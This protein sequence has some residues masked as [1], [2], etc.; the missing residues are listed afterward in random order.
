[1]K[2]N[3]IEEGTDAKILD[4]IYSARTQQFLLL[5]QYHTVQLQHCE[6]SDTFSACWA[7]LVFR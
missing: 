7:I 3:S 5:L 2:T 1:M 4:E 6:D